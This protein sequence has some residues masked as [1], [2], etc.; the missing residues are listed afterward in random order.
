MVNTEVFYGK[1]GGQCECFYHFQPRYRALYD[2]TAAD[3]DEISINEGDIIVDA[4]IIDSGWMEGRNQRTGQFG[5][6]PSNYV[7]EI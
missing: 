6:L 7:E 1:T 5:M 4:N 2:Y 3:E